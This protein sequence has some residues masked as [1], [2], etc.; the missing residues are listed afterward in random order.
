MTRLRRLRQEKKPGPLLGAAVYFNDP[1]FIEMCSYL[2]FSV[3]WIEM[4]HAHLTFSEAANLCRISQGCGLLTMIR[5]PNSSRENVLKAAECA[6]DIIDVPMANSPRDLQ[7]LIRYARFAPIGER[8]FFSVSRAVNYGT[9]PTVPAEQ[10][11]LNDELCLMAQIETT[12]AL[13]SVEEICGVPGVDIF[14]GPSDLAASLGVPGETGHPRVQEAGDLVIRTAKKHGKLVAVGSMP[15]DFKF[16]TKAGV[17]VLFCTNDT[18]CL[19][20]GAQVVLQ[21]ARDAVAQIADE[22]RPAK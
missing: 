11:K 16:W 22:V 15:S 18:S 1:I 5:I 12:E 6:P 17:D 7:E 20:I 3:M 14:I 2:G 9:V 19:R 10:Q 21:Q 13:D 8:G 4:E